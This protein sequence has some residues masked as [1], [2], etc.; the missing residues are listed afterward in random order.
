MIADCA[1]ISQG[2]DVRTA[3]GRD[4]YRNVAVL[5]QPC[6]MVQLPLYDFFFAERNHKAPRAASWP[7]CKPSPARSLSITPV[8]APSCTRTTERGAVR[9]S[10]T[11]AFF[12]TLRLRW[13]R[14]L[15]PCRTR[16]LYH[17]FIGGITRSHD[18][19]TI[20]T[21][22]FRYYARRQPSSSNE[23]SS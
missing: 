20:G 7:V 1:E 13:H 12:Q 5:L 9:P 23:L 11:S 22:A 19:Y 21:T 10:P 6:L 14:A 15:A 8:E 3:M 18:G 2:C 17:P 16:S 4:K